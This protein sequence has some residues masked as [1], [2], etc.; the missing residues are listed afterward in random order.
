[1]NTDFQRWWKLQWSNGYI[2]IFLVALTALIAELIMWRDLSDNVF[3]YCIALAIPV[4][5]IVCVI[6]L[7]FIR[8]WNEQKNNHDL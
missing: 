2:F 1:M 4:T 3:F 5:I 6:C 7:A 8:F